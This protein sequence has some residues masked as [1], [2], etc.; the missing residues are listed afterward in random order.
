MLTADGHQLVDGMRV[1]D[2]NL[3]AGV[4]D[5]SSLGNDGWF[6]VACDNGQCTL[7]NAVRV[8]V[9]HPFTGKPA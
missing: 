1:W 2:Y 7:M 8:C 6:D 5:L 4:V 3:Y 9:R